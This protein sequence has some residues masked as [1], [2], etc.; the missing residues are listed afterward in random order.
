MKARVPTQLRDMLTAL[1]TTITIFCCKHV[2]GTF[3]KQCIASIRGHPLKGPLSREKLLH[4][5]EKVLF[6]LQRVLVD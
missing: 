2:P 3:L 6:F 1:W 4:G 5:K